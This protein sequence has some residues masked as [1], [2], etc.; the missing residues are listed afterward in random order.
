MD[1]TL[2][3]T[4]RDALA[5]A[6]ESAAKADGKTVDELAVEAVQRHLAHRTLENFKIRAEAQRRGMTDDNVESVVERAIREVR[7]GAR[8]R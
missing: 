5:D 4:I 8:G 7:S 3:L 2:Q 1:R 6:M